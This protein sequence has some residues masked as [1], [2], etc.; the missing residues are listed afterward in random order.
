M[1]NSLIKHI[2]TIWVL[3]SLIGV[4]AA[5]YLVGRIDASE[6]VGQ[7]QIE[8]VY[9][10]EMAVRS[11]GISPEGGDT[12]NASESVTQ[13]NEGSLVASRNGTRYYTPGCS[14]ISRINP[15]NRVYFDTPEQAEATGLTLAQACQE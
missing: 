5:L 11:A 9:P 14:G 3:V 6:S 1:N 8:V 15:E 10:D 7:T 13:V 4:G 2:S 12:S